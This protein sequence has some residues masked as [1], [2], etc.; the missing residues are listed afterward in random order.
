MYLIRIWKYLSKFGDWFSKFLLNDWLW[1]LTSIVLAINTKTHREIHSPPKLIRWRNLNRRAFLFLFF[2]QLR[3]LLMFFFF[4]E[5]L[6]SCCWWNW[7]WNGYRSFENFHFNKIWLNVWHLLYKAYTEYFVL[8][9]KVKFEDFWWVLTTFSWLK[10]IF[11]NKNIIYISRY[12]NR[13]SLQ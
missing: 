2:D 11:L 10:S 4:R 9:K 3:Y 6:Y 5:F 7:L 8:N 1:R 13:F 12:F